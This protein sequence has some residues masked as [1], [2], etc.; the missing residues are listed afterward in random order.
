MASDPLS[1]WSRNA[2][3][4][5]EFLGEGNEFQRQ[6]IMPATDRLI[7]IQPG[8]KVLD[9]ACGNGNYA[10]RLAASGATVVAFDGAAPFI[11]RAKERTAQAG[12]TIDYHVIDAT[13]ESAML[14]LGVGSFDAAVC[15]M[16]LMDFDPITPAF[17]AIRQLLKPT[18][19][20]VFSL[21]HPCFASNNPVK[22]AELVETRGHLVHAYGVKVTRY[23]TEFQELSPGLLHQPE[24]HPLF[25]RPLASIFTQAFESGFVMDGFEEPAFPSNVRV[26]NVFTWA[27][28]PEIPPA[29]VVRLRSLS[30][31]ASK[32]T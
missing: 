1:I 21:P 28:R 4:W 22:T 9:V 17:R 23:R 11:E 7:E 13:D 16:A 19:H 18:G 14:S 24:P 6:L 2:A 10:R 12:L 20:F 31:P 29:V 27:K 32:S 8:M 5:D 3:Y 15:S 25:H 30:S 26:K